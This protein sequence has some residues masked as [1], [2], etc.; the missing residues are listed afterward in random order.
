VQSPTVLV[1]EIVLLIGEDEVYLT[2]FRKV[3]RLI[4][5]EPPA[6]H[7]SPEG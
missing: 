1:I 6:T 3:D 4:E 7:T 5:N 2:A